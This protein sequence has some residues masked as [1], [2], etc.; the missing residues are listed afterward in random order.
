MIYAK[1]Q[2]KTIPK[3]AYDCVYFDNYDEATNFCKIVQT[4]TK[5]AMRLQPFGKYY[6]ADYLGPS[7]DP[8][9]SQRV[10]QYYPHLT[11]DANCTVLRDQ[12][13]KG[14]LG[15]GLVSCI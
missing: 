13:E 10:R 15:S 2:W 11:M 4:D 1:P 7:N 12:G 3:D 14:P 6:R 9:L 5:C 8:N